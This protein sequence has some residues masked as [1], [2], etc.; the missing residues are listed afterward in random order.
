[1]FDN[2]PDRGGG[3]VANQAEPGYEAVSMTF[4]SMVYRIWRQEGEN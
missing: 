3:R 2:A 4:T 1:M